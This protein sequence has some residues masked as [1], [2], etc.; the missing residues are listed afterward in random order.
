MHGPEPVAVAL[1]IDRARLRIA[2]PADSQVIDARVR[3]LLFP[4]A[5]LAG[6]DFEEGVEGKAVAFGLGVKEL[7]KLGMVL[8]LL[9]GLMKHVSQLGSRLTTLLGVLLVCFLDIFQTPE[10]SRD[11]RQ[12]PDGSFHP[13]H[14]VHHLECAVPVHDKQVAVRMLSRG[15]TK[16]KVCTYHAVYRQLKASVPRNKAN[17]IV[18]VKRQ[19]FAVRQR[20]AP[21]RIALGGC[22]TQ[23]RVL[24]KDV[25]GARHLDLLPPL[26][27]PD[28]PDADDEDTVS[29]VPGSGDGHALCEVQALEVRA[30][31]L[32][33]LIVRQ[34]KK[35]YAYV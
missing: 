11:A 17:Q 4:R 12:V 21:H 16:L 24:S 25:I 31:I 28:L 26:A 5:E 10:N 23:D 32:L 15:Q 2:C 18:G 34:P 29:L 14:R 3:R 35:G 33:G 20:Q 1:R 6:A 27:E 13:V 19:D 22:Q 7:P 8:G 9:L 30:H